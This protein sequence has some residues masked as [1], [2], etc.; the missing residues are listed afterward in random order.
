MLTA[1]IAGMG[2]MVPDRCPCSVP[3]PLASPSTLPSLT[4]VPPPPP[5]THPAAPLLIIVLKIA[6]MAQ[7]RDWGKHVVTA[8]RRRCHRPSWMFSLRLPPSS[9]RPSFPPSP[10]WMGPTSI[11][12]E[13]RY[14]PSL[15]S[16]S[17]TVARRRA[18]R[19]PSPSKEKLRVRRLQL[20][21]C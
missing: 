16:S 10:V 6:M 17:P 13:P 11:S 18:R 19:L 12:D 14:P 7:R 9:A 4:P 2:R 20:Q 1:T 5:F 21:R 3:L 8:C 15:A